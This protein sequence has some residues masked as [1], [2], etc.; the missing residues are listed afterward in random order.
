MATL[1]VPAK[2][3]IEGP[4]LI[5]A[6]ELESLSDVLDA[7][8]NKLA[9]S[10]ELEINETIR[11]ENEKEYLSEDSIKS[12]IE[13]AKARYSF[14]KNKNKLVLSSLNDNKLSDKTL[15]GILRDPK[16]A[17]FI[18][19]ELSVDIEHGINNFFNLKIS[20]AS[21]GKLSYQ[22][23]CFDQEIENEIRYE[24]DKWIDKNKPRRVLQIWSNHSDIISGLFGFAA[25]IAAILL[26]PTSAD[27]YKE[28]TKRKTQELLKSGVNKENQNQAM[29]L[30]LSNQTNY[31]PENYV[32]TAVANK[33][34]K[35]RTFIASIVLFIFSVVRPKTTIGIG[36]RKNCLNFYR[37]WLRLVVVTIPVTFIV[38]PLVEYIKSKL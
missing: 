4:W 14:E 31:T 23:K 17:D 11:I 10:L 6:E 18:P 5:G 33:Q 25:F 3:K 27:S 21:K 24:I 29:E 26:F 2:R 28:E 36:R 1:T 19:R 32:T 38:S 30:I 12:K 20:T 7:I 37:I 22:L 8:S 9:A 15:S 35:Q 16:I 34:I 13:E